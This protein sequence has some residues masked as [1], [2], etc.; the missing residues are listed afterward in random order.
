[1]IK[2]MI[3]VPHSKYALAIADDDLLLKE[4]FHQYIGCLW[5]ALSRK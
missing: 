1:M 3:I 5:N 4:T 2:F